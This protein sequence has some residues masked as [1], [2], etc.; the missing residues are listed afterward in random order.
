[1]P[2]QTPDPIERALRSLAG[3]AAQSAHG[4]EPE[5]IRSRGT[6]RRHRRVGAVVAVS[7]AAV[8]AVGSVAVGA[9]TDSAREPLPPATELTTGPIQEDQPTLSDQN[10]PR[11]LELPGF[12]E[13]TGWKATATLPGDGQ[14]PISVCQQSSLVGLGA[15]DVWQRE[16][17][18][19]ERLPPGTQ[20]DPDAAPG[21]TRV[22]IAQFPDDTAAR[23]AYEQ[24]GS[25]IRGCEG[26]RDSQGNPWKPIG[27]AGGPGEGAAYLLSYPA[28][29]DAPG[30][31]VLDGEAVGIVGNRI[32]LIAQTQIG[33]D[34]NY[35]AGE[36]PIEGALA[37][38]LTR[39]AIGAS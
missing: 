19:T 14:S 17:Q 13:I 33:Q 7:T 11:G 8:L 9:V 26:G 21:S 25:W 27:A 15:T 22:L 32:V 12:N 37:V 6:R 18:M 23:D 35:P 39:L 24:V 10:L 29:P 5:E 2:D 31:A 3:S 38:A 20:A 30:A 28:G 4:P 16:Y 36:T 34:Y 1:M